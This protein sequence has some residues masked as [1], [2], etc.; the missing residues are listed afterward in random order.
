ME[1]IT[2]SA[3]KRQFFERLKGVGES[4][5]SEG[6]VIAEVESFL[7]NARP[8]SRISPR[9]RQP[10]AHTEPL[11]S[12][13]PEHSVQK[14]ETKVKIKPVAA[15]DSGSE[16]ESDLEPS[17]PVRRVK[18]HPSKSQSKAQVIDGSDGETQSGFDPPPQIPRTQTLATKELRDKSQSSNKRP[19]LKHS[20]SVPP[21]IKDA[22]KA[23]RRKVQKITAQ[24]E[25]FKN[26]KFCQYT[27]KLYRLNMMLILHSFRSK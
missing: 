1:D 16:T 15:E 23:K 22:S 21:V 5:D 19:A 4:D 11:S 8:R 18:T 27:L 7:K 13:A 10:T 6:E 12:S 9:R 17:T 24:Y 2:R 26:K 3:E 20:V 14:L 25:T